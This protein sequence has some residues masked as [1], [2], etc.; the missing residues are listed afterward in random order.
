MRKRVAHRWRLTATIVTGTF[1]AFGSFW[2][3][4]VM[5]RSTEQMQADQRLNEPDYIIDRFSI[6]RMTK[7]GQPAYIVSGDKLVHRPVGDA[8]DIDNPRVR[9]LTAGKPPM[10][11]RAD[12]ARVDD[13]NSRVQLAGNVVV[14]RAATADVKNLNLKTEALTVYPDSERMETT[15]PVDVVS[16]TAHMT[17]VGMKADN[18]RRQLEVAQRLRITYPPVP[19]R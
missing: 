6:V 9:T 7:E 15:A 17:G 10:N 1:V 3:L 19:P 18:A 16:G 2:L 12:R 14:D 8:S 5:N 11:M 4:E 13:G